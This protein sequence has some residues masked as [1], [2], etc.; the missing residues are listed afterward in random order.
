MKLLKVLAVG[1][2]VGGIA[3]AMNSQKAEAAEWTP[4][5]VEEIKADIAKTN[6]SEYTIVWGD[7]LS[8]ISQATNITVDALAQRNSIA[9]IDLIYAGNKL[10]FEGDVVTVQDD[11]GEVVAQSVITDDEKIDSS[12]PI[13]QPAANSESTDSTANGSA[14]T[15][16]SSDASS[17][18]N[19]GGTTESTD[20]GNASDS[21]GGSD[22]GNTG[23]STGNSDN[24]NTGGSTGG[25]D[26]SNTGD[27]TGNSD[28]GN[29]G[30]STGGSDNGNTGTSDGEPT[31]VSGYIGNTGL[32]FDTAEEANA[33]GYEKLNAGEISRFVVIGIFYSDGTEK[34]SLDFY[35]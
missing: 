24:G 22:S 20:N 29:T 9:N 31:I 30:G 4:R 8:G 32:I 10:I 11:Q 23:D 33:Y 18:S 6:G 15:G 16:T 5:S 13:G 34:A 27:S 1:V 26:S 17:N 7:T 19:A 21:T 14:S 25:S 28:N 2:T 3:L 35:Y 12:K